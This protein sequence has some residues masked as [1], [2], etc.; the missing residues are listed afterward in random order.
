MSL[1]NLH[2]ARSLQ[3]LQSGTDT[4]VEVVDSLLEVALLVEEG[5]VVADGH[6]DDA[7]VV[8]VREDVAVDGQQREKH[9][10]VHPLLL[11]LP[12]VEILHAE[13]EGRDNNHDVGKNAASDNVHH[14]GKQHRK[15]HHKIVGLDVSSVLNLRDKL[16]LSFQHTTRNHAWE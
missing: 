5:E 11:V 7:K 15:N 2:I 16:Y 1:L 6:L 14:E 8:D 3:L 4:V 12:L 13:K 10:V 9:P